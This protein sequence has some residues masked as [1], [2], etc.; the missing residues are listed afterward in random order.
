MMGAAQWDIETVVTKG[1]SGVLAFS[2]KAIREYE[3]EPVCIR[4]G[5]CVEGCPKRLMPTYLALF[6]KS[7]KLDMCEKYDVL[8]CVECGSCSYVCPGNVPIVQHIRVAKAKILEDRRSRE[9]ALAMSKIKEEV[10][11]DDK[12]EK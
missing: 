2:K 6:S 4:C 3:Q 12:I 5:R 10:K 7:G 9:Q 8:S 1:T 11:P